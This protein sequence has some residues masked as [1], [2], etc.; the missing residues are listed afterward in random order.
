MS[1]SEGRLSRWSRLKSKG[2]ADEREEKTVAEDKVKTALAEK[3]EDEFAVLPG[4]AKVRNFVPA[5]APLAPDP[6]DDDDDLTRGVGHMVPDEDG[7]EPL[8]TAEVSA[9]VD[10]ADAEDSYEPGAASNW[11]SDI[12]EQDLS[13][14][15][16]D[17][18]GGLPKI[19]DLNEESD[20]TVFLKDGVPD[21]IKRRALRVL[22]RVNPFFNF[23][24]GLAEY[25]EDYNVVHKIID[26]M[27]GH[28]QVG[29][30]HLSQQELDDMMPEEAKRAFDE[31]EEEDIP[32]EDEDIENAELN[33]NED[34]QSTDKNRPSE[35]QTDSD[36]DDQVG[37][38]DDDPDL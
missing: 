30:G 11:Y 13:D 5:M 14:E 2:G 20:Y 6:E 29:R 27:T 4:G 1:S 32:D 28:Y 18:V 22:W 35:E 19:E 16:R 9:L 25:D 3:P 15:E 23:T 8:D 17:V 21:F 7:G 10:A 37:E 33:P 36:D 26:E 24:D 38:G 34:V 12:E 31:D